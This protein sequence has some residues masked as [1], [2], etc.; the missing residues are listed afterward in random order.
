MRLG[1]TVVVVD[2]SKEIAG[3]DRE[4]GKS[5]TLRVERRIEQPARITDAISYNSAKVGAV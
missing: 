1:T 2:S 3:R 4:V 5:K